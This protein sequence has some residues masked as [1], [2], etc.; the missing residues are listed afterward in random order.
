MCP[1]T[2]DAVAAQV[3]SPGP[4]PTLAPQPSPTATEEPTPTPEPPATPAPTP[5]AVPPCQDE[6]SVAFIRDL[7]KQF[8][9]FESLAELAASTP[10]LALSGPLGDM[11]EVQLDLLEVEPPSCAREAHEAF[12]EWVSSQTGALQAFLRQESDTRVQ[13]M[14]LEAQAVKVRCA[15]AIDQA[16]SIAGLPTALEH[17]DETEGGGAGGVTPAPEPTPALEIVSIEYRVTEQN[18]VFWRFAWRLTVRNQSD[19]VQD[20]DAT[21]EFQD[22][23]G[24][25]IDSGREYDLVVGPRSEKT[26][27]G[28][29]LIDTDVA[30]NVEQVVVKSSR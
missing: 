27:T 2:T 5:T 15:A 16:R 22:R 11:L 24:F 10:R 30:R 28:D 19:T 21:L 8:V 3:G 29:I 23:D 1:R 12:A 26:F 13:V 17:V 18:N 25:I 7:T 4:T 6:D 14:L 20:F 9:T